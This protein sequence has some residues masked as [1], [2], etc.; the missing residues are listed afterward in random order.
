MVPMMVLVLVLVLLLAGVAV[1][2]HVRVRS[3][4]EGGR[5]SRVGTS[6]EG[7]A[8]VVV[9]AAVGR[10]AGTHPRRLKAFL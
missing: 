3:V 6:K 9:A 2:V 1:P 4:V 5:S 10:R 8:P 7:V